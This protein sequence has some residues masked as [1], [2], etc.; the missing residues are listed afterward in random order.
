MFQLRAPAFILAAIVGSVSALGSQADLPI[1]NKNIA[2]DG[3]S[4][5]WVFRYCCQILRLIEFYL[6]QCHP[7]RGLIPWSNNL[8]KQGE[9]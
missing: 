9:V 8:R 7:S 6:S 3:F 5:V 2:P 1:S 4:R